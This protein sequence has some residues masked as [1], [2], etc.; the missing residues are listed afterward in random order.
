MSSPAFAALRNNRR[1]VDSEVLSNLDAFADTPVAV[2][3]HLVITSASTTLGNTL[4]LNNQYTAAVITAT[5]SSNKPVGLVLTP[6]VGSTWGGGYS[7]TAVTD[8]ENN[9]RLV[10]LYQ[11]AWAGITLRARLT[12]KSADRISM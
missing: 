6:S 3:T 5:A 11:F 12:D 8:P 10:A 9:A 1:V 4:V 7:L 2:P